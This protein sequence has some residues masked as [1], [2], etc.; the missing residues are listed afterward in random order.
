MRQIN[1]TTSIV[2]LTATALAIV[3]GIRGGAFEAVT[4][5]ITVGLSAAVLVWWHWCGK[6][7]RS[8]TN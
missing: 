1:V 7:G 5:L 8:F 6:E 3:G 4:G 2:L